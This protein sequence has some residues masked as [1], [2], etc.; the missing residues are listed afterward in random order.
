MNSVN[1]NFKNNIFPFFKNTAFIVCIIIAASISV[2][3]ILASLYIDMQ[4]NNNKVS[5]KAVVKD[6]ELQK[7]L[8]DNNVKAASIKPENNKVSEAVYSVVYKNGKYSNEYMDKLTSVYNNNGINEVYLT[9]DDGPYLKI[10]DKILDILS[11][12]KIPATFFVLGLEA[13]KNKNLIKRMINEGHSIGNH[14]YTHIYKKIYSS[15]DNFMDEIKKSE[16]VFKNIL[17]KDFETKL[18]RMPG[19]SHPIT[20]SPFKEELV[21]NGYGYIDWNCVSGDSGGKNLPYKTLISN[22]ERTSYGKKDIVLLM[23]DTDTKITTMENLQSIID[24]F[25]NKGYV[26]CALPMN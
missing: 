17:G 14:T 3:T 13:E 11:Q 25:K 12:N 21:K 8:N 24:Y 22:I 2:V 7:T 1:N 10:T 4:K 6:F 20:R 5:E 23:H 15:T 16:L 26:F 9:F 18:V 19:G